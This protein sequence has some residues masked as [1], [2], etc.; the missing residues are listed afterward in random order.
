MLLVFAAFAFFLGYGHKAFGGAAKGVIETEETAVDIGGQKLVLSMFTGGLAWKMIKALFGYDPAGVALG[1]LGLLY[2]LLFSGAFKGMRFALSVYCGFLLAFFLLY[3]GAHIRYFLP[4]APALALGAAL[5]AARL[6]RSLGLKEGWL[7]LPLVILGGVQ[8]ARLDLLLCRADTRDLAR[9]WIEEHIPADTRIAAEGYTP[10]LEPNRPSLL[11]LRDEASVWLK[12]RE[13]IRLEGDPAGD[14]GKAYYLI[15]LERFYAFKSYW[16]HQYL[17]GGERP[18]G[19]FLDDLCTEWIVLSDQW[20]EAERHP[21]LMD[22][23]AERGTLERV[24]NPAGASRPSEANLPLEMD[25]ALCALW[26]LDRPGPVI[27]LFKIYR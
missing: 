24:F 6:G 7:I 13:T 2:G 9:A 8:T 27:S 20:P 1:T 10:N 22:H 19:A 18:I 25:F 4:V 23:L 17:L 3:E 11:F 14:G 15:P 5:G 26:T 21:P 12:R 16:P